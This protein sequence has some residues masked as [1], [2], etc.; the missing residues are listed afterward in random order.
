MKGLASTLLSWRKEIEH[1]DRTGPKSSQLLLSTG[2]QENKLYFARFILLKIF[3][4]FLGGVIFVI[5]AL[6]ELN[7]AI[8]TFE[9]VCSIGIPELK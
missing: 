9:G 2:T 1:S 3:L 6:E 8:D 7:F 4:Q 5:N